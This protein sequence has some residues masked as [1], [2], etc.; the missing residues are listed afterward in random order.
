MSVKPSTA[1]ATIIYAIVCGA[2]AAFIGTILNA[3]ILYVGAF[4]ITWGAVVSLVAATFLFIY[5]GLKTV[6]I[7]GTAAAGIIAY[8][9]VAWSSLDPNNRFIVPTSYFEHFP[10]PAV[11]GAIWMYG[12]A[13]ATFIALIAV[14]RK[15][16][17][18][19]HAK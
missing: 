19:V 11:A 6:R 13:I 5:V 17:A 1:L 10:G 4:P 9:L 12:I 8:A 18:Q 2:V 16:K 3:Q 15:I 14:A 7:W